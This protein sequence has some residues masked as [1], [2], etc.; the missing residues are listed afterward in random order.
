MRNM[1][2]NQTRKTQ[3]A[4]E[5]DLKEILRIRREKL[6]K[7]QEKAGSIQAG[8]GGAKQAAGKKKK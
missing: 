2:E 8:Q 3:P 6:Q 5:Q 7:L 4:E 1:A